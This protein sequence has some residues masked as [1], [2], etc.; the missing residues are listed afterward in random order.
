M[1]WYRASETT[2]EGW[3]VLSCGRDTGKEG[4]SGHCG[5]EGPAHVESRYNSFDR[6]M[7]IS[8]LHNV[9]GTEG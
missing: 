8:T 4:L 7:T 1:G 2:R 6:F 5:L 9:P 3:S